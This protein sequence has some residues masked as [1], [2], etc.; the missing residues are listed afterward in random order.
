MTMI[1]RRN[2][3]IG[4]GTAGIGT[5]ITFGSGAFTQVQA[6]RDVTISLNNDD[7]ADT[8]LRLDADDD[9]GRVNNSGTNNVLEFDFDD[10]NDDAVTTVAPGFTIENNGDQPVGIRITATDAAGDPSSAVDG[11]DFTSMANGHDLNDWP[12]DS[13]GDGNLDND[14]SVDVSIE[15]DTRTDQPEDATE[16]I[17]EADTD[18]YETSV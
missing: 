18:E 16:I 14:E 2:V 10:L 9:T 12:A 8:Y 3:L 5:G 15:I 4:L 1:N 11:W 6:D 13:D 7:D 17:I